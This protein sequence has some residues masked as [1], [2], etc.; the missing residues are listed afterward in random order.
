M[1]PLP[2]VIALVLAAGRGRRFGG[3]KRQAR[4]ADGRTLLQATLQATQRVFAETY[5]LL[6]A[7]DDPAALEV[8]ARVGV[9]RCGNAEQGL[10]DSL[11]AGVRALV[12]HPAAAIAVVLGD[13]P[14]VA[15]S[16]LRALAAQAGAGRIVLG[17]HG[18]RYG[19][20]VLFGRQFWP[21]LQALHGEPGARALIEGAG[22]A[23]RVLALDDPGLL[24]DV[25][26]PEALRTLGSGGPAAPR[27][28]C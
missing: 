10:G 7:E 3:D 28:T 22:A 23:C 8:P 17:S 2:L 1:A 4:L 18:G 21:P 13:M 11:A 14:W 9:L 5:V 20:P 12:G 19:H 16:S 24:R 15:E 25:D 26:T 6:R 27:R